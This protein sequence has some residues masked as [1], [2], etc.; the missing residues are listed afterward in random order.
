MAIGKALDARSI[1]SLQK[2]FEVIP[3]RMRPALR[4]T[5][6]QRGEKLVAL[7]AHLAP[8]G[9]TGR[10]SQSGKVIMAEGTIPAASVVNDDPKARLI[11]FGVKPHV[12]EV[13]WKSTLAEKDPAGGDPTIFGDWVFHPGAAP[14]PFFYPAYR[15]ERRGIRAAMART[16][17]KE[18][19][20]VAQ[21]G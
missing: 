19:Q 9:K 21:R 11:E 17:R 13:E 2:L 14:Q 1:K 6:Q 18:I 5:I 7:Q 10:L 15:V 8:K 3:E 16:A 20:K 4:A 12:V